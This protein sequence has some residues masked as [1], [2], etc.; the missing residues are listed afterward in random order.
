[1][2]FF[3]FSLT[4]FRQI[5]LRKGVFR[6]AGCLIPYFLK[7]FI[8]KLYSDYHFNNLMLVLVMMVQTQYRN[9]DESCEGILPQGKGLLNSRK[10]R[11]T[12]VIKL[13][14]QFFPVSLWRKYRRKDRLGKRYLTHKAAAPMLFSLTN[15]IHIQCFWYHF[16]Q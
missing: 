9:M 13:A 14:N 5:V 3:P 8:I 4:L 1:M 2:K 16:E 12:V 11:R 6:T 7:G 10:L 15:Q